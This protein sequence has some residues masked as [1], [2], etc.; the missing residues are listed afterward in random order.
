VQNPRLKLIRFY[1]GG[2]DVVFSCLVVEESGH[3][4]WEVRTLP[5]ATKRNSTAK[6]VVGDLSEES[7]KML[8]QLLEEEKLMNFRSEEMAIP[9]DSS[10]DYLG[11]VQIKRSDHHQ[12]LFLGR[13]IPLNHAYSGPYVRRDGR[14]AT[15]AE[16]ISRPLLKWVYNNVEKK[17][18][19]QLSSGDTQCATVDALDVFLSC[20]Q[21]LNDRHARACPDTVRSGF[22][23]R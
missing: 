18:R 4:R 2:F 16:I 12:R 8:Q 19:K 21:L 23:H 9:P 11:L 14:H 7:N 22:D 17:Y 1:T 20:P 13:F 10:A 3:F 15:D 6:A 5:E